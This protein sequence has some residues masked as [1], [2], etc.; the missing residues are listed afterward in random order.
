MSIPDFSS[1]LMNVQEV[2]E[3]IIEAIGE[4]YSLDDTAVWRRLR[5]TKELHRFASLKEAGDYLLGYIVP[6]Q[7]TE[8]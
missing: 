1:R 2:A 5:S 8:N 3:E 6:S 7:P 4:K